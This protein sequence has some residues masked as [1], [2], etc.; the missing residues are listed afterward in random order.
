MYGDGRESRL[1][2]E[3]DPPTAAFSNRNGAQ[4]R[5]KGDTELFQMTGRD[6][7]GPPPRRPGCRRVWSRSGIVRHAAG[8][9][10]KGTRRMPSEGR[11]RG[12]MT[13]P[14]F[15]R[16]PLRSHGGMMKP[17]PLTR[18]GWIRVRLRGHRQRFEARLRG[19]NSVF[20]RI[21]FIMLILYGTLPVPG[22]SPKMP[23]KPR[24]L[25]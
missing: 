23:Q 19:S 17:F 21:I 7:E 5:T 2:L 3:K 8:A 18:R 14:Y 25:P 1:E 20:C 11:F 22:A 10:Q 6:R 4:G 9:P 24:T 12:F 16:A 15:F 13:V